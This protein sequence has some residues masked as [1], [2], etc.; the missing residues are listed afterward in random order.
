M[1]AQ[2]SGRLTVRFSEK[3]WIQCSA[4]TA[5]HLTTHC[6]PLDARYSVY[7]N[8]LASSSPQ[9]YCPSWYQSAK[10][11]YT[12]CYLVSRWSRWERLCVV[13]SYI[14]HL[15]LMSISH[16]S[17]YY[18]PEFKSHSESQKH[19]IPSRFRDSLDRWLPAL[20]EVLLIKKLLA[21][22]KYPNYRSMSS[23][24]IKKY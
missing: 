14:T 24:L 11:G 10:L 4:V 23:L 18:L 9:V 20:I 17:L 13:H 5:I 12:E 16:G 8:H 1:P 6:C 15:N 7:S 21:R 19:P 2:G 3:M 22:N